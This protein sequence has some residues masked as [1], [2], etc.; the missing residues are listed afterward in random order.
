[1]NTS[2]RC[3]DPILMLFLQEYY[4]PIVVQNCGNF[5]NV[6]FCTDFYRLLK[7]ALHKFYFIIG[8]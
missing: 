6:F 4:I 2:H 5:Y 8:C 1:M 7:N 3:Q